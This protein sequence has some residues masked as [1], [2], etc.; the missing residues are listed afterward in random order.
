MPI[1]QSQKTSQDMILSD[2]KNGAGRPP[3]NALPRKSTY[4]GPRPITVYAPDSEV[5]K[6]LERRKSTLK[7]LERKADGTKREKRAQTQGNRRWSFF[8][9][10]PSQL[11][12][13]R[14]QVSPSRTDKIKHSAR[15]V[16][17]RFSV[18]SPSQKSTHGEARKNPIE[19]VSKTPLALKKPL[20][21]INEKIITPVFSKVSASG[22]AFSLQQSS[23]N[24][25]QDSLDDFLTSMSLRSVP[26]QK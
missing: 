3:I 14:Q 26:S 5:G 21:K 10:R 22:S 2:K 4:H 11:Q 15:V 25:S 12:V 18:Y 20:K 8:E 23:Q 17:E 19:P 13:A 9:K 1:H 6:A 24:A 7:T 16:F